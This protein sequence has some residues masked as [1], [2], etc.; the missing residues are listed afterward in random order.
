MVAG[1]R[2]IPAGAAHQAEAH[3]SQAHR[4]QGNAVSHVPC[5]GARVG[6]L[7]RPSGAGYLAYHAVPTSA[8][9][10]ASFVYYVT[11]HWRRALSCRSR[12]ERPAW[13]VTGSSR[14]PER[15]LRDSPGLP[16]VYCQ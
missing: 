13:V 14:V 9:A 7:V 6:A 10:I 5:A 11:W 15:V 1:R 3:A 8:R 16:T 12:E 4:D 2:A